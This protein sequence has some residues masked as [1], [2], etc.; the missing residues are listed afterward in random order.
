MSDGNIFIAVLYYVS[1]YAAITHEV[2]RSTEPLLSKCAI[3][4]HIFDF[5][6]NFFWVQLILFSK[7]TH[8]FL[9]PFIILK[10][11]EW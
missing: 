10:F 7:V 5:V 6:R 3:T 2:S 11:K 8:Y 1:L 4:H 9:I